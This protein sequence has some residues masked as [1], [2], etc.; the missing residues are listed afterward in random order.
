LKRIAKPS[1]MCHKASTS[2][3]GTDVQWKEDA[4]ATTVLDMVPDRLDHEPGILLTLHVRASDADLCSRLARHRNALAEARTGLRLR[5]LWTRK[6][7]AEAIFAAQMDA[8]RGQLEEMESAC[9]PLPDADASDSVWERY[10][11]RVLAWEQRPA[12]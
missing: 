9:G 8:Q 1:D 4:T 10:E 6:S 12:K 11:R 2:V 3:R 7:L 5:R